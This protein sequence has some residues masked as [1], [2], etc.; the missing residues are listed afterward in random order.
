MAVGVSRT[1]RSDS[2]PELSTVTM[3]WQGMFLIV[4]GFGLSVALV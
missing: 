1:D 2:P 3:S 4:G